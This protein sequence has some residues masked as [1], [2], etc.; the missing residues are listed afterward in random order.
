MTFADV[1]NGRDVLFLGGLVDAVELVLALARSIGRNDHRLQTVD[2][3]E[4]V[5]FGV[6]RARH[7]GQLGVQTEVVLEG[8]GCQRLVLWL[9]RHALLG[10]HRL[11]KTIA[12]ATP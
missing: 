4:L 12:P 5:G 3:L 6:G 9:D 10:L 2:F 8:D 7:A 1:G 11:V